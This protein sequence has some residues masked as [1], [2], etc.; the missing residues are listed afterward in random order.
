ME[1]YLSRLLLSRSW[2]YKP[3]RP[4]ITAR[5]CDPVKMIVLY[6]ND[7]RIVEPMAVCLQ[8]LH[9]QAAFALVD[10]FGRVLQDTT[11]RFSCGS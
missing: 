6:D 9:G 3:H 1:Q 5:R 10:D 8:L 7:R 11:H 2:K 4:K